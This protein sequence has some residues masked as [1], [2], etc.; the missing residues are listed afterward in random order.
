MKF[1]WRFGMRGEMADTA[2]SPV[3]T[4]I[5]F[6]VSMVVIAL[7]IMAVL[8]GIPGI[9]DKACKAI[10]GLCKDTEAARSNYLTARASTESLVFGINCV[11]AGGQECGKKV[12]SPDDFSDTYNQ[13]KPGLFPAA[14]VASGG[15]T[16]GGKMVTVT[17]S[18]KTG[19][20]MDKCTIKNFKL[21]EEFAGYESDSGELK[22]TIEQYIA[23]YGDPSY[24][25][26]YQSFPLGENADWDF[27]SGWFNRIGKAIMLSGCALDILGPV[28]KTA[29]KGIRSVA[30]L[31]GLI[32]LG[33]ETGAATQ[34]TINVIKSLGAKL[35]KF[36]TSADDLARLAEDGVITEKGVTT[37]IINSGMNKEIVYTFK[38]VDEYASAA[39]SL[40]V[41]DD[42]VKAFQ[43]AKALTE[44]GVTTTGEIAFSQAYTVSLADKLPKEQQKNIL[45]KFLTKYFDIKNSDK[46]YKAALITM[47]K[48][49]IDGVGSY[50]AARMDSSVCK[51]SPG[52]DFSAITMKSPFDNYKKGKCGE[53]IGTVIF[54]QRIHKA[55]VISDP[56]KGNIV[57]IMEPVNLRKEIP[58][59]KDHTSS[60]YLASPCHADLTIERRED[61]VVCGYYSYDMQRGG[62]ICENPGYKGLLDFLSDKDKSCG[63]LLNNNPALSLGIQNMKEYVLFREGK[64]KD[65]SASLVPENDYIEINDF[66]NGKKWY[67]DSSLEKI[68]HISDSA[69]IYTYKTRDD[70]KDGE[71]FMMDDDTVYYE[72]CEERT[73]DMTKDLDKMLF[74]ENDQIYTCGI[75]LFKKGASQGSSSV[76]GKVYGIKQSDGKIRF[77]AIVSTKISN[78]GV[79]YEVDLLIDSDPYNRVLDSVYS[80]DPR[81]EAY[82]S[83]MGSGSYTYLDIRRVFSDNNLDGTVDY[84]EGYGC[85]APVIEIVADRGP[86]DDDEYNYCYKKDYKEGIGLSLTVLGFAAQS[87]SKVTRFGGFGAWAV[88]TIVD[89]G[90]AAVEMKLNE[91]SWP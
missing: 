51:F 18:G 49:G 78:D 4:I 88:S 7:I 55:E 10:P 70:A 17:C 75:N 59:L 14:A 43:G 84:V 1:P 34:K 2:I 48:V 65:F 31:K 50:A 58:I 90:I 26:Y 12:F 46:M 21:P 67:F 9:M 28:F 77:D 60:F 76:H 62:V 54:P 61:D 85:R 39:G 23:G 11:V 66:P 53:D 44:E 83:N 89:C 68:T 63:S 19:A 41:S 64:G 37:A 72:K 15:E 33:G 69:G 79:T 24:L 47:G 30:S 13:K 74:E 36:G 52:E 25:V 91:G 57:D 80:L 42:A 32:R 38:S 35:E 45:T 5:I 22:D 20:G 40:S 56:S 6:V 86:Y 29:I 71:Y 16:D 3:A 82:A 8:G 81:T 27:K 73:A 87:V